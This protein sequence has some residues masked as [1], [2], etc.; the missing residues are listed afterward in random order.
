LQRQ[1]RDADAQAAA[2]Q[3]Q[4]EATEVSAK[5]SAEELTI[6]EKL[7]H[8]GY[9][10]RAR[11]LQLER[12]VADYRSRLAE[13]RSQ[14]SAANQRGGDLQS[15]IAQARN[16]YQ[17]QAADEAKAASA[18]V[19]ELEERLRPSRD[20]VE[21]QYVRAPVDGQ[22]MAL[23]VSTVD[24]VI[25]PRQPILDILP[26]REKLVV[27]A[28]IRPED[29]NNVH[30]QQDAEVRLSSLDARTT[31]LLQGKVTFVS[32]DR[33]TSQDGR[34]SWF[35]AN[36]EVDGA[37]LEDHPEIRLQAGMPAELFV[38]TPQ[39]T[40]LQYFTKPLNAFMGRAMREP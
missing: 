33:M 27:E 29:I 12:V 24:E 23:R 10:Q 34:E 6:N 18:K 25:A 35:V 17:Q 30:R 4:I 40:V 19:R 36:V 39:R 22:I 21:R 3:A 1:I 7:I 38:T 5:L 32:P 8:D 11:V 14:L 9:V 20:Q 31:P 28:R 2:L 16:Q 15:R 13:Q 26:T 37:A